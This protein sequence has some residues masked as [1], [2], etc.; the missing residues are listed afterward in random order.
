VFKAGHRAQITV[1]GA[2][3]RERDRDPNANGMALTVL[4]D[5]AHLSYIDLPVVASPTVSAGAH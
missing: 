5:H 4:A 3:H 2:D 1:T